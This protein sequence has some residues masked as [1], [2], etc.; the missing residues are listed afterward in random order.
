M[1]IRALEIAEEEMRRQID[2]LERCALPLAEFPVEIIEAHLYLNKAAQFGTARELD[3]AL[4]GLLYAG[5]C[6][7]AALAEL[8]QAENLKRKID[9]LLG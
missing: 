2:A 6:Y 7:G 4:F 3:R 5:V 9:E 1:M 8:E